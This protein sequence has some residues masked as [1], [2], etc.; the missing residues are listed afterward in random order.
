M[1]PAW[2]FWGFMLLSVWLMLKVTIK[3]WHMYKELSMMT[4]Y[5]QVFG[6][7]TQRGFVESSEMG[8]KMTEHVLEMI[9]LRDAT[10]DEILAEAKAAAAT[11]AAFELQ[12]KM[13]FAE[14]NMHAEGAPLVTQNGK[15]LSADAVAK[16]ARAALEAK[17]SE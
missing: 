10:P 6:H 1:M 17:N 5:M 7:M 8:A 14:F 4:Y 3:A 12:L 13:R 2:M 15:V 16:A 9:R 11:A